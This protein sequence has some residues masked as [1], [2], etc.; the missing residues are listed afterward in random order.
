MVERAHKEVNRHV[1]H[2]CLGRRTNDNR[3]QTLSIAQLLI[4]H[5]TKPS[6]IL[7][8]QA[9]NLETDSVHAVPDHF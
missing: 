2:A 8:G 7:F 6:D 3:K 5:I 4:K 9:V 1:R